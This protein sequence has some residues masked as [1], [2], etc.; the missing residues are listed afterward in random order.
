MRLLAVSWPCISRPKLD[1][2]HNSTA[3]TLC[4]ACS[5]SEN[6]LPFS[7]NL[8]LKVVRFR[9]IAIGSEQCYVLDTLIKLMKGY[10]VIYFNLKIVGGSPHFYINNVDAMLTLHISK[11]KRGCNGEQCGCNVDVMW[12]IV[13]EYGCFVEQCGWYMEHCGGMW[14]FCGCY[15]EHCGGM[16]MFMEKCGCSVDPPHLHIS[17]FY[18]VLSPPWSVIWKCVIMG[19]MWIHQISTLTIR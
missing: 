5:R 3:S 18:Q 10:L 16:W 8:K 11:F 9:K 17:Q 14:M 19:V 13:E 6:R 15:E 2:R 7:E 4:C 1:Q 12:N